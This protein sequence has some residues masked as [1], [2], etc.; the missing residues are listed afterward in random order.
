MERNGTGHGGSGNGIIRIRTDAIP[1]DSA[2]HP[3]PAL[4]DGLRQLRMEAG[5]GIDEAARRSGLSVGTV[6]AIEAGAVE[7]LP[8]GAPGRREVASLCRVLGT[9]PAAFLDEMREQRRPALARQFEHQ[10]PANRRSRLV[11]FGLLW[12]L[13]ALGFTASWLL[14]RDRGST[15]DTPRTQPATTDVAPETTAP[16]AVTTVS[17][18]EEF[19][20]APGGVHEVVV[21]AAR[22]DV[23]VRAEADAQVVHSGVVRRGDRIELSGRVVDVVVSKPAAVDVT[24]DAR[25]VPVTAEMHFGA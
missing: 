1:T 21:V 6:E 13:I 8:I 9:D 14:G 12:A 3:T 4:W 2:R 24:V 23:W 11:V 25:A 19:T 20:P 15:T 7:R 16:A 18:P 22:D 17:S 10:R 5:L